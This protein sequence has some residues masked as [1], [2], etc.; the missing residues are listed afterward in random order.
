VILLVALTNLVGEHVQDTELI[1]AGAVL[2]GAA[3]A[4]GHKSITLPPSRWA[5]L[6]SWGLI[7]TT[8]IRGS[9]TDENDFEKPACLGG[10]AR[11]VAR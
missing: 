9:P 8:P 4:P 7:S 10:L 5:A 3:V 2:Y 6:R 11:G 1:T